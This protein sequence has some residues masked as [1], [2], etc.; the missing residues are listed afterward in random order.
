[1]STRKVEADQQRVLS[2]GKANASIPDDGPNAGG[3][4]ST[5][6]FSSYGAEDAPWGRV[7]EQRAGIDIP[8]LMEDISS[9]L[10]EEV[11]EEFNP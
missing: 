7:G 8:L 4:G 6:A 3:A 2:P 5:G 10:D 11:D 9:H 1:M